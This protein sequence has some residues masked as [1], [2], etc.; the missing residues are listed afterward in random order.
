MKAIQNLLINKI[1]AKE[2]K[3]PKKAKELDDRAHRIFKVEKSMQE[4]ASE[5]FQK[6]QLKSYGIKKKDKGMSMGM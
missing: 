5:E 4:N 6:E 3:D 2:E 1:E